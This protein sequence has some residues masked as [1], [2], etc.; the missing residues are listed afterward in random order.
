MITG[1][2]QPPRSASARFAVQTGAPVSLFN[3]TSEHGPAAS[4]FWMTTLPSMIGEAATPQG[5]GNDPSSRDHFGFPSR[6]KQWIP[7][8]PK[9]ATTR[10]PSVTH[11]AEANVF[12]L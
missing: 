7:P 10:S 4:Q 5:P 8:T 3:A 9:N 6:S 11:D 1:V 12:I 2:D